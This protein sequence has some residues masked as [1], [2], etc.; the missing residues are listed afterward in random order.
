MAGG[1]GILNCSV[2][3]HRKYKQMWQ[4]EVS[5]VYCLKLS[6]KKDCNTRPY[7]GTVTEIRNSGSKHNLGELLA[8]ECNVES[9]ETAS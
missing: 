3:E 6:R 9:N 1:G 5:A 8:R 4:F 7:G 2:L